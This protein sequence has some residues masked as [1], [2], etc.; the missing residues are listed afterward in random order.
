MA[1]S[2]VIIIRRAT[3]R[4]LGPVGKGGSVSARYLLAVFDSVYVVAL[5]TW[6]GSIWFFSFQVAPILFKVLGAEAGG[7]FVRALFPRYYRWGAMSGSIAL[8]AFVAGPLCFPEYRGLGVGVQSVALLGCTLIMLYAGNSLVPA[9][10][11]AR[12]A[13]PAGHQRFARLHRRSVRLN[14]LV[15]VVGLGLLVAFAT[16]PLPRTDGIIEMNPRERARY[17]AAVSRV[18]EDLEIRHGLRPPRDPR[19]GQPGQA[20][21][22]LDEETVREIESFYQATR[23]GAETRAGARPPHWRSAAPGQGTASDRS[24]SPP[25]AQAG[26]S[27]HPGG[28]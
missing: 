20:S 10:N 26:R 21:P 19:D 23:S 24:L 1:D 17:E 14:G 16:R 8:P 5:T 25:P 27:A 9:I 7:K 18:I 6:M 28:P 13:G 11:R 15:L 2:L 12:D 3:I 22:L 4:T